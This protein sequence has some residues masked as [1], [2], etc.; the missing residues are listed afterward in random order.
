MT[1]QLDVFIQAVEKGIEQCE[2]LRC[3]MF[4]VPERA[5]LDQWLLVQ[6]VQER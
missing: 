6:Q 5:L 1:V 3:L 2:E 4:I